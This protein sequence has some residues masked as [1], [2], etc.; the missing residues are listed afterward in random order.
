MLA[1]ALA[2]NVA[3]ATLRVKVTVPDAVENV[4]QV[5]CA[6]YASD[7]GFPMEGGKARIQTWQPAAPSLECVFNDLPAGDYAVAL[8]HDLNGNQVVDT[9]WLGM[10][11]EAWGVSRNARP[12]L[13]APRFNE[14]SV[15]VP[16]KGEVVIDVE[17]RK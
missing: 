15:T 11:K 5:G 14:A 16:A 12:A 2:G 13:R 7:E 9:N 4:G 3:A 10:P 1:T 17:V 6:L 8:S